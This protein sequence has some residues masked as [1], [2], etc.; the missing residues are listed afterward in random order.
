MQS[1]G[2]FDFEEEQRPE[3]NRSGSRLSRLV[4]RL[5][6]GRVGETQANYVLVGFAVMAFVL[7]LLLF[8][9]NAGVS[10]VQIP[11]AL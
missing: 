4:V 7:S 2:Q 5:S 11:P 9:S 10:P 1:G 8:P 6:G 3:Y